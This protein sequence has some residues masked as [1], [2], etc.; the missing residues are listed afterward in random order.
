MDSL[1]KPKR[2]AVWPANDLS[3]GLTMALEFAH[4]STRQDAEYEAQWNDAEDHGDWVVSSPQRSLPPTVPEVRDTWPDYANSQL[5]E[6]TTGLYYAQKQ[7]VRDTYGVKEE[8]PRRV[9]ERWLSHER[10]LDGL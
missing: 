1:A 8:G 10:R 4:T 7:E 9:S 2:L 3:N 5:K 6:A